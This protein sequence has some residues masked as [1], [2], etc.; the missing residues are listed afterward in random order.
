[1]KQE[2]KV[3]NNSTRGRMILQKQIDS[4][5]ELRK[6]N[7]QV[8]IGVISATNATLEIVKSELIFAIIVV[9][10]GIISASVL[11]GKIS[12]TV[13]CRLKNRHLQH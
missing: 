5:K 8:L 6:I 10:M 3:L 2:I 12:T 1:M 4:K 13:K 11:T 7:S 9:S